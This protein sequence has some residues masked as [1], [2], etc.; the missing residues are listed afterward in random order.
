MKIRPRIFR[1]C[2]F[3]FLGICL[4]WACPFDATLRAYL[5]AHFWLPFSKSPRHFERSNVRR[6]SVPFAGMAEAGGDNALARLRAAYQQISGLDAPSTL[7]AL[8]A[9]RADTSLTRRQ[10]EEVDLIDAKIDIRTAQ[11]D[12]PQIL[13]SA[14]KKIQVFFRSARTPEFRSEARGWLAHIYF[15]LGEQTAAGKIYLDELN[16]NGSNLSRETL[17]NSLQMTYRNNGGSKLLAHLEE[18]FDTPEHAAFAIQLLTNPSWDRYD[19]Q[20]RARI[21][22]VDD[23]SQPYKSIKAML[24]KH[25]DLLK[26]S[27]GPYALALLG[28]R[29]ALSMGDPAAA[30]KIGEAVDVGSPIRSEADFQW[31]LASTYFLSRSYA[32]AE[33]PLLKLFKSSHASGNQ[34]AAAAYGLCGVYQKLQN[35]KEQL[36]YA[37]WLHSASVKDREYLSYPGRIEDLSLYWAFSGWDLGLL[38]EN[39]VPTET[40]ESFVNQNPAL[41]DIRLVKYSLAVRLTREDRYDEAAEIFQ[42]IHAY[43]RAPRIRQLAALQKE[44]HRTGLSDLQKLEAEYRMAEFIATNPNRIYFNDGLWGGL[45]RYAL[46]SSTESRMNREERQALIDKERKLKDDQEEQWRAYLILR[47]VVRDAGPTRLR[48]KAALLALS[49]LRGISDRFGRASD[50][51]QAEI[52]LAKA[53]H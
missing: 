34:K 42:S 44:A 8:A 20:D 2:A 41:A 35:S 24:E 17:L 27:T 36:R 7:E 30:V 21:R 25:I 18:Y 19:S 6:V 52:H 49:S 33:A 37:L 4:A 10:R 9:A 31:M 5:D 16:R 1:F 26:T 43:R 47:D 13:E 48:R 51:R 23:A 29:T 46:T 53:I 45:Q 12:T 38:L 32:S 22:R 50:I 39:E 15:R 28:M 11:A 3:V 40:L 14:K